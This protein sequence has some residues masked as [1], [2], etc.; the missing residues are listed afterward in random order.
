MNFISLKSK[1]YIFYLVIVGC[2]II[3]LQVYFRLFRSKNSYSLDALQGN[4]SSLGLFLSISF[5]I[6]QIILIG[7]MLHYIY[8]QYY[9]IQKTSKIFY[10]TLYL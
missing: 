8:R 4:L 10:A 9:P 3:L 2:L 6:A 1:L 5:I 7:S